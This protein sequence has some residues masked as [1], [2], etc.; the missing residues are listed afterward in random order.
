MMKSSKDPIART[1]IATATI[2]MMTMTTISA[3]Q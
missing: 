2:I 1:F 3:A